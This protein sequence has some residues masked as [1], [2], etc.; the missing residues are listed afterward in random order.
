MRAKR[1][2]T[3]IVKLHR[4]ASFGFCYQLISFVGNTWSKQGIL[5]I[6]AFAGNAEAT[7]AVQSSYPSSSTVAFDIKYTEAMDLAS[8]GGMGN[9]GE[10]IDE[11][12]LV[13][14]CVYYCG[15]LGFVAF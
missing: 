13:V 15:F 1:Y 9:L 11:T 14:Y 6:E 10:Y 4:L 12:F 8:E 7:R 2:P 5:F 3:F